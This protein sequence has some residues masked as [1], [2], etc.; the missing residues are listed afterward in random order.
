MSETPQNPPL[1]ENPVKS[2]PSPFASKLPLETAGNR[3]LF[4]I[5][6]RIA[7]QT[8]T[9]YANRSQDAQEFRIIPES[10]REFW[11]NYVL[12]LATN[13]HSVEKSNGVTAYTIEPLSFGAT[14]RLL[15][16]VNGLS[17]PQLAQ[18]TNVAGPRISLVELDQQFH[19]RLFSFITGPENPLHLPAS[20]APILRMKAQHF[21]ADE[22]QHYIERIMGGVEGALNHYKTQLKEEGKADITQL[23]HCNQVMRDLLRGVS[24]HKLGIESDGERKKLYRRAASNMVPSI[25]D[26]EALPE[27][28]DVDINVELLKQLPVDSPPRFRSRLQVYDTARSFEEVLQSPDDYLTFGLWL[29]GMREARGMSMKEAAR[30][31]G[32]KNDRT[33]GMR[34]IE[35]NIFR[36]DTIAHKF[37]DKV[38][39]LNLYDFPKDQQGNIRPDIVQALHDKVEN[40]CHLLRAPRL[41]LEKKLHDFL[42]PDRYHLRLP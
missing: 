11:I 39:E 36:S 29:R 21:K 1:R 8:S 25:K 30:K 24:I 4:E 12:E 31:Y 27:V 26:L 35:S 23:P 13:Q 15:R 7:S 10:Q 34:R 20:G 38:L 37:V 42:H 6:N 9:T 16:I 41:E 5:I 17:V 3:P 33:E 22:S 14:L 19:R 2:N 32:F 18:Q 40:E 28:L